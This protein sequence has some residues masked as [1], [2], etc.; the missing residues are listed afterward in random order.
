[1]DVGDD[2]PDVVGCTPEIATSQDQLKEFSLIFHPHR[3]QSGVTGIF[4]VGERNTCRQVRSRD[5][6]PAQ[7]A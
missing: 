7:N 4:T 6:A 2:E 3:C 1:M 5:S